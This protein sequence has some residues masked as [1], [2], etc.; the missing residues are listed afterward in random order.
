MASVRKLK[1][2]V[3]ITGHQ[4]RTMISNILHNAPRLRSVNT[5]PDFCL[6][7]K[8][9][10][11]FSLVSIPLHRSGCPEMVFLENGL[12]SGKIWQRGRSV[13]M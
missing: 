11:C 2:T 12:Q 10:Y 5:T 13:S 1:L 7:D 6:N 4:N 8:V 9:L 3:S